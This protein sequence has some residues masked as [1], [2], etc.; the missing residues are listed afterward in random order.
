MPK[1]RIYLTDITLHTRDFR[2][3]INFS[4]AVQK[5]RMYSPLPKDYA[6][7]IVSDNS[8]GEFKFEI[9]FPP[10]LERRISTGEVELM[11]PKDGLYIYAGKDTIEHLK[12]LDDKAR[13]ELIHRNRDNTWHVDDK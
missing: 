4:R 3:T 10:D 9:N 1:D 11:M 8:S 5:G 13:R 12:S 2:Q 7:N 6:K